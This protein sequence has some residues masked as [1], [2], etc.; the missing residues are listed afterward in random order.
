MKK[1]LPRITIFALFPF[2][3]FCSTSE[4][5]R[6]AFTVQEGTLF[7]GDDEFVIR[8]IDREDFLSSNPSFEQRRMALHQIASV[9]GNTMLVDCPSTG[10]SKEW[11]STFADL[12]E[13]LRWVRMGLILR[14]P[15]SLPQSEEIISA[16]AERFPTAWEVIFWFEG[17]EGAQRSEEFSSLAGNLLTAAAYGA[18]VDVVRS[19]PADLPEKP[20]LLVSSESIPP[21]PIHYVLKNSR[22]SYELL[23]YAHTETKA[24]PDLPSDQSALTEEE[25]NQGFISLFNSVDFEGWVV[26]GNPDGWSIENGAITW[27]NRGGGYIR[28]ARRFE[29]F[30]LRLEWKIDSGGNSGIFVRAPLG[31]RASRIGMEFQLFGDHGEEPHKNGTGAIYDVVAPRANA[32]RP[33]GEWNVMEIQCN[34]AS[35]KAEL[36]GIVIHDLDLNDIQELRVRLRDGF[37]ALQDHGSP[38]WFRNIRIKLL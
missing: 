24:E 3:F 37:I 18:D 22:E 14:V 19:L 29:D 6:V 23:D 12:L 35:V 34:G 17:P 31:G 36:N 8:A 11:Y 10:A 33:A 13:D 38:V 4:H 26:T 20:I 1:F 32:S 27:Q 21:E 16:L 5:D 7:K 9:G 30:I 28:S 15:E 25:R 2:L